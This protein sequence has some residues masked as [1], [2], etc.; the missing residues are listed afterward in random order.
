MN[1]NFFIIIL[2]LC[3]I[4]S[5][6]LAQTR[7]DYYSTNDIME[8]PSLMF[9]GDGSVAHSREWSL[10]QTQS[11][12]EN[13]TKT[14]TN[15]LRDQRFEVS[16]DLNTIAFD[17]YGTVGLNSYRT[18]IIE[19]KN[20]DIQDVTFCNDRSRKEFV[21][22]KKNKFSHSMLPYCI[23]LNKEICN[24]AFKKQGVK[25][26]DEFVSKIQSCNKIKQIFSNTE[27]SKQIKRLTKEKLKD[28]SNTLQALKRISKYSS[29]A[30]PLRKKIVSPESEGSY[31]LLDVKAGLK[32]D[33]GSNF[34]SLMS[35]L[36]TCKNLQNKRSTSNNVKTKKTKSKKGTL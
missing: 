9:L 33:V 22:S 4:C 21:D 36:K 28:E 7:F 16:K 18:K 5:A 32:K 19:Y 24:N 30:S 13:E 34:D 8:I 10:D 20:G 17:Y 14:Y 26:Y 31:K 12:G 3:S 2:L 11:K 25:N 1:T 23:S 27:I 15:S 6:S 35:L 29:S